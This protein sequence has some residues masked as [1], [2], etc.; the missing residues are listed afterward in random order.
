MTPA[1]AEDVSRP[2]AAARA[3][4]TV[5]RLMAAASLGG[6]ATVIGGILFQHNFTLLTG[7]RGPLLAIA[8]GLFII[9]L[10]VFFGCLIGLAAAAIQTL[11]HRRGWRVTSLALLV[12]AVLVYGLCAAGLYGVMWPALFTTLTAAGVVIAVTRPAPSS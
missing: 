6:I 3:G 4:W 1:R 2:A 9:G 12:P 8:F 11:A 7:S 5:H 10:L